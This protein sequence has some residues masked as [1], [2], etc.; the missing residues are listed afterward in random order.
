MGGVCAFLFVF[1]IC[2]NI[3]TCTDLVLTDDGVYR[4]LF[5]L[6]FQHVKWVNVSLVILNKLGR[7]QFSDERKVITICSNVPSGLY[8][9]LR[10]R[11]AVGDSIGGYEV[12]RQ[13]MN[14][15]IEKYQI[16]VE[17]NNGTTITQA[18]ALE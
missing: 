18:T 14:G 6:R 13:L 1:F 15:Y 17:I 11:V 7:N 5:G 16:K 8:F 12:F 3:L 4:E 10:G 9:L 2:M